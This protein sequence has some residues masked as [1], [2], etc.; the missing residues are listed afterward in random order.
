MDFGFSEEQELLRAEVRKFLDQECPLPEVRKLAETPEGF[1]RSQWERIGE[2]GWLGLAL[3]EEHGGA[4]L[5]WV[6]LAV[7]LE[8]TGRTLF[9]SPLVATQLASAAIAR[10]GDAAQRRRWLSALGRGSAIGTVAIQEASDRADAEGVALEARPDGSGWRLT[11]EKLFVPDAQNADLL[12]VAFRTGPAPGALALGVIERGAPGVSVEAHALLDAT[13]RAGRVLL[14]GARVSREALLGAPGAAG[15]AIANLLD[16]GALAVSAAAAGAAAA[17]LALTVRYAKQRIQFGQPIGRFQGVKH[18]LAE[19]HVDVESMRSLV[20]YAA[21]LLD[22][23]SPEAALAVARAKA[24]ASEAFARI[25][26]DAIQLHGAIGY[27]W[28]YDAQLYLKR[29]KST[30]PAFGDAAWHYERVAALG[31]LR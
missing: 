11:G 9:P 7:V 5:G 30:R 20:Y 31:V 18:P 15:P 4:G 17:A 24:W 1:S 13:R 21:W 14:D 2:L 16:R 28:E 3:P 22:E 8:E 10:E 19:M 6:D 25:G 12:V 29:A 27:T 23:R 26:I